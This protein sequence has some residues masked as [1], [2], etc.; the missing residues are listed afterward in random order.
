V[1][2]YIVCFG[3]STSYVFAHFDAVGLFSFDSVFVD[4]AAVI[5][6]LI[7]QQK[8]ASYAFV[9]IILYF[10]MLIENKKRLKISL[11]VVFFIDFVKNSLIL[12]SLDKKISARVFAS[13]LKDAF[14]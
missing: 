7:T 4:V 13:S 2:S 14:K 11:A 12:F 10:V 6:F 1:K 8:I 5:N 3:F 9:S